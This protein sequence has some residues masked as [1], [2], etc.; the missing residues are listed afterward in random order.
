[1]AAVQVGVSAALPVH[2]HK[3]E[4]RSGQSITFLTKEVLLLLQGLCSL[5]VGYVILLLCTIAMSAVE[6]SYEI[7]VSA[8]Y[9]EAVHGG[10]V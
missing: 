10:T 9:S 6:A 3:N 7:A 4:S 5:C 1:M 2:T 8:F